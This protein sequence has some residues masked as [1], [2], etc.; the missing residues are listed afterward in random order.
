MLVDASRVAPQELSQSYDFLESTFALKG[1]LR[2]VR[3]MNVNTLDEVPDSSWFTNRITQ[4]PID[5]A[6]LMRGANS[7]DALNATAW[8]IVAGKNTDRSRASAAPSTGPATRSSIRWSSTRRAI[9][10]LATGAEMIG[11][12]RSITRSVI[13]WSRTTSSTSTRPG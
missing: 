10:Q 3:A 5:T 7:V 4:R 9:P 13:T 1:D 8:T 6:E 11:T 2:D 12:W